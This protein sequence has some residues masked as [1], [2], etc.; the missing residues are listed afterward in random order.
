ML[1][2]PLNYEFILY[3]HGPFSFDFRDELTVLRADGLLVFE[4]QNPPYGPRIS[5]TVLSDDLQRRFPKTL[6]RY[7]EKIDF[8]AEALKDKG[9]AVLERLS[10]ALYVTLEIGRNLS[11][12]ERGNAL[13]RLKPHVSLRDAIVAVNIIDDMS[14]QAEHL[15][16]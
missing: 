13:V 12:D 5:T 8:V 9:V 3:K 10:T 14:Q 15:T 1:T 6:K 16:V 2:V 4:P 11:T 7:G